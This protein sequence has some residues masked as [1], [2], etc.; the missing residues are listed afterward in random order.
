[1]RSEWTSSA[2]PRAPPHSLQPLTAP[3]TCAPPPP[4]P[5]PRPGTNRTRI[6][7]PL[8]YK[9][10]THLSPALYKSDARPAPPDPPFAR[11]QAK[12]RKLFLQPLKQVASQRAFDAR[13]GKVRAARRARSARGRPRAGSAPVDALSSLTFIVDFHR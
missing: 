6:S 2:H 13:T 9:S 3:L 11:G 4:P 1:M 10:D 8:R 12:L 5:P 7:P